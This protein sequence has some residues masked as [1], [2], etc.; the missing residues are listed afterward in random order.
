MGHTPFG[1]PK[2][3]ENRGSNTFDQVTAVI[4]SLEHTIS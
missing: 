4:H 2:V 3:Y 1:T